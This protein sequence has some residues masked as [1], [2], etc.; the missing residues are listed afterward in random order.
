M[1]ESW[2]PILGCEHVYWISSTGRIKS[3]ARGKSIIM[4]PAVVRPG[5][6]RV[7]LGSYGSYLVHRLVAMS[8]IANPDNKPQV[9]HI[10]GDKKDNRVCNLEW[11]TI[12]E[13]S[14][15]AYDTGLKTVPNNLGENHSQV[16]L[17]ETSVLLI[18][19]MYQ[20]GLYKQAELGRMFKVNKGTISNIVVRKSW[21]HI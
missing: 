9:N 10:N 19:V 13:N 2:F 12:S 14:K 5:Y 7:R 8:F 18:R 15:H 6:L 4:R 17:T 3:Y 21:K 16:K 20:S 1:S 11:C